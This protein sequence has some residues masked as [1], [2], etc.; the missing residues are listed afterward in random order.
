MVC[1]K[2]YGLFHHVQI[3]IHKIT[4]R[5]DLCTNSCSRDIAS[6]QWL[7]NSQMIFASFISHSP[8]CL[9]NR[10]SFFDAEERVNGIFYTALMSKIL[11]YTVYG[12]LNY[13]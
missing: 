4:V 7:H 6:E 3:G 9:I 5:K 2:Y 8:F 11:L 10:L 1:H 13:N 12:I